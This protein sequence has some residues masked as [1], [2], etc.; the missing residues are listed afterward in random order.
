MQCPRCATELQERNLGGFKPV[1]VDYCPGC[2]GMWL[3]KGELN[4]LDDSVWVNIEEDV[5]FLPPDK[6][7]GHVT[8]PN[9]GTVCEPLSPKDISGCIID[10][11]PSCEGFWLDKDELDELRDVVTNIHLDILEGSKREQEKERQKQADRSTLAYVLYVLSA[12]LLDIT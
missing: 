4:R 6:E 7:H 1:V 9:C 2:Q 5:E 12:G 3:D 10:R 8:C 11:C